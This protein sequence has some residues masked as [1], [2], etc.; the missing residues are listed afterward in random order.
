MHAAVRARKEQEA[1]ARASDEARAVGGVA[2]DSDDDPAPPNGFN[3]I[4]NEVCDEAGNQSKESDEGAWRASSDCQETTMPR[5]RHVHI[6][7][8]TSHDCGAH[9]RWRVPR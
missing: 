4:L 1:A 3:G 2:G 7:H 5:C 6:G 8:C 9:R